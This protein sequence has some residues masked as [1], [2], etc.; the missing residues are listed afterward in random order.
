MVLTVKN[1]KNWEKKNKKDEIIFHKSEFREETNSLFIHSNLL[2]FF[3]NA[4]KS[5]DIKHKHLRDSLIAV[6]TAL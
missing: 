3:E 5:S 4:F 2:Y 1:I 6:V